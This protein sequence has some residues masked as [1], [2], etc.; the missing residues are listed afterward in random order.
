[1]QTNDDS[2]WINYLSRAVTSASVSY[3]P[4]QVTDVFSQD[5]AFATAYLSTPGI[6]NITA[7][8]KLVL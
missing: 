4:S 3:L 2:G 5:R 8:T 6:K 7:V 1:M